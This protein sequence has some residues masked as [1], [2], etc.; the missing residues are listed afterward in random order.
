MATTLTQQDPKERNTRIQDRLSKFQALTS[1]FVFGQATSSCIDSGLALQRP[2][3]LKTFQQDKKIDFGPI[4]NHKAVLQAAS[5]GEESEVDITDVKTKATNPQHSNQNQ[6]GWNYSQ[7]KNEQR[8]IQQK[9]VT[10]SKGG[11]RIRDVL[12]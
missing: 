4:T 9:V 5:E 11:P 1:N 12:E 8:L 3:L 6:A 7:N 2:S 10:E